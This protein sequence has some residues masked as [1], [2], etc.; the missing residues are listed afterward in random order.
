MDDLK[1]ASRW[2]VALLAAQLVIAPIANFV[3]LGDVFGGDGGFL[4]N[5]APHATA[6]ASAALLSL[7]I[8]VLTAGIAVVLWPVLRPSCERLALALAVLGAAVIALSG[9]E[10]TSL[11]SM[12]SLS[13]A[14]VAA[15]APDEALYLALRGVVGAQ[16]NWAHLVQ[17]LM[18]GA[19]L[20]V[21][22]TALFRLRLVPRWLAGFGMLAATSQMIGVTK[23]FFGGWVVFPMLVP[24]GAV[25]LVLLGWLVFRGMQPRSPT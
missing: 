16:R 15:G 10:I 11:L 8:A 21:M 2:L 17:L 6:L 14:Y 25:Q 20:L 9:L 13:Q 12:L 3:L 23:P 1:S 7:A 24:L 4:A 5:A 18:G 22:Y 19:V